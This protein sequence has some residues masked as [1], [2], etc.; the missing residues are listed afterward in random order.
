MQ[1]RNN[2]SSR[3]RHFSKIQ[4]GR[5]PGEMS[6]AISKL[7]GLDSLMMHQFRGISGRG[8]QSRCWF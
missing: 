3:G 1:A 6:I 4:N 8:S 7:K 5:H 2:I